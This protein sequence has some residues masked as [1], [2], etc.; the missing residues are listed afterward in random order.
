MTLYMMVTR[1]KYELPMIV[2]ESTRELADFSGVSLN[3]IHSAI[4]NKKNN[5]RKFSK[6]VKVEIDPFEHDEDD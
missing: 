1:D 2:T 6:F 5:S 3:A 4:I